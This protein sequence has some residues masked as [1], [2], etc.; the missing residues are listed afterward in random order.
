[1]EV[2]LVNN[3][4]GEITVY[5]SDYTTRIP[6]GSSS[7]LPFAQFFENGGIRF[8]NLHFTYAMPRLPPRD[9]ILKGKRPEQFAL[10]LTAD[11]TL[12]LMKLVSTSGPTELLA[13]QPPGYPLRPKAVQQ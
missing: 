3:S 7:R 8:N 12:H 9:L 6:A 4:H 11:G 13:E 1:M 10:S 2:I 5:V